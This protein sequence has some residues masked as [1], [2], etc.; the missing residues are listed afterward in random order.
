MG[1]VDNVAIAGD[2]GQPIILLDDPVDPGNVLSLEPHHGIAP[3]LVSQKAAES[4]EESG[5]T[6]ELAVEVKTEELI[7]VRGIEQDLGV[8]D[9]DVR[10]I[11]AQLS[12]PLPPF[13][14]VL[15]ES[16]V[17]SNL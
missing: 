7:D 16:A 13:E 12:G 17:G 15:D 8:P 4:R 10:Q 2:E 11:A 14:E 1:G 5:F 6:Q 3:A 9:E